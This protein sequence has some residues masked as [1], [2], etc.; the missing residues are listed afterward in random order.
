M[1][2]FFCSAKKEAPPLPQPAHV[3]AQHAVAKPS[4]L[5]IT[6][7]SQPLRQGSIL[8]IEPRCWSF[9]TSSSRPSPIPV[10]PASSNKLTLLFG[11]G[12]QQEEEEEEGRATA[13]H[14]SQK[15]V[16]VY[17]RFVLV[18]DHRALA[19]A[20]SKQQLP[21]S[22]DGASCVWHGKQAVQLVVP[23]TATHFLSGDLSLVV[24][25][26]QEGVNDGKDVML[27]RGVVHHFM[28]HLQK[29]EAPRV[30]VLPLVST[31]PATGSGGSSSSSSSSKGIGKQDYQ[32][33]RS[34]ACVRL[35]YLSN[36][37]PRQCRFADVEGEVIERMPNEAEHAGKSH[38]IVQQ[39]ISKRDEG[40]E[41]E[42]K[43]DGMKADAGRFTWKAPIEC[44]SEEWAG[45]R[46]QQQRQAAPKTQ[47][48]EEERV[49]SVGSHLHLDLAA[50]LVE[51]IRQEQ[52]S[53]ALPAPIPG[54]GVV[55][56]SEQEEED[57]VVEV[58]AQE[59]A[60]ARDV[61]VGLPK[62]ASQAVV[63]GQWKAAGTP[64]QGHGAGQMVAG[65]LLLKKPAGTPLPAPLGEGRRRHIRKS[66]A[67]AARHRAQLARI[68]R[69]LADLE[70]L[71]T[72]LKGAD[73]GGVWLR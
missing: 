9:L 39:R 16:P 41:N 65:A 19:K 12:R 58:P 56:S 66:T 5:K 29:A 21:L 18:G 6:L 20:R 26:F 43:E 51:Q 27:A 68:N 55:Q 15:T 53:E 42:K 13:K 36:A 50:S 24:E 45:V 1:L 37:L 30:L 4:S 64:A 38:E 71:P 59:K 28:E 49:S 35:T 63:V 23:E 7:A 10:P 54:E 61:K 73:K 31:S 44:G 34:E 62:P 67:S 40:E 32:E 11:K 47:A 14:V 22:Y 25:V 8:S 52:E 57:K 46:Q 48:M 70:A 33:T 3:P 72:T 60:R 2:S 69:L 17:L